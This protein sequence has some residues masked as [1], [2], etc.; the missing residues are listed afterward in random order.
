MSRRELAWLAA[1]VVGWLALNG[2]VLL[3]A[4]GD[5]P[6]DWPA[7]H[8]PPSGPGQVI[9][10]Q[11][12][13]VELVLLAAIAY[14]LTRGRPAPM[15]AERAPTLPTA[16]R[17]TGLVLAYGV[18]AQI[19]GLL[20][21]R[22]LGWHPIG[23]HLAGTLVGATDPVGPAEALGW[24][25]YNVV[26]YALLPLLWFRRRYSAHQMCL[27]SADRRGDA[28]LILVVLVLESLAQW[29]VLGHAFAG[30]APG[31]LAVGVPLTFLLYFA[32]TVLPTVIFVQ[33]VLVPRYARLTG[34]TTATIV[35]GG[36]TYAALHVFEGWGGFGS[37][38]EAMLTILFVLLIYT[39]PGAFKTWL[40][41]RTGN[42][43]VHA[44][45]Y[46]A[47]APHT[48]HDTGLIVRIFRL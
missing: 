27:R 37:P 46:H 43:W 45:A 39:L 48:M 11:A 28:I 33:S 12:T 38:R 3:L 22:G 5:A 8:D 24:A 2:A 34:S 26:V 20:I 16:R 18:L 9:A 13:L 36:L 47:F 19:G 4:P 35:L 14:A 6:F 30:L 32:G 31:Q 1:A 25:T 15:I 17:E 29:V 44:W 41:V 40:T 23:F 42:A 7:Q 21:G 10:A